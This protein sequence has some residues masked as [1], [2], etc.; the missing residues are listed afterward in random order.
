MN[1]R[2]MLEETARRYGGKTALVY[3]NRQVSY[4][5]L[6]QASN[7]VANAL[8][9]MGVGKGERVATLLSDTPEFVAVYFRG[10]LDDSD[11][12]IYSNLGDS[13]RECRRRAY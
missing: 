6:D 3:G 10:S 8:M 13:N 1:L 9:K 5:E 2:T 7:R 12:R 4:A 11:R